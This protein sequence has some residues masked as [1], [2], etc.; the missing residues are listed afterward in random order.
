MIE[1]RND[2]T[3]ED[4]LEQ[5]T[6][7]KGERISSFPSS[8][9][10]VDIET[11][12]F[13]PSSDS[14][15]E[16]SA[17]KIQNDEIVNSF[18]SLVHIDFP[19]PSRIVKLTSITD[20]MLSTAPEID[21]VILEFTKFTG[22]SVVVG[23]NVSFDL[24][25][26]TEKLHDCY[27]RWF[28]NDYVDTL[29]IARAVLPDLTCHKL[30]ALCDFLGINQEQA[31][32]SLSDCTATWELF[33]ILK[34]IATGEIEAPREPVRVPKIDEGIQLSKEY[35]NGYF[36]KRLLSDGFDPADNNIYKISLLKKTDKKTQNSIEYGF[37]VFVFGVLALRSEYKGKWSKSFEITR[38]CQREIAS[39]AIPYGDGSV[40][41]VVLKCEEMANKLLDSIYSY[42]YNNPQKEF[43][44]CSR[45]AECSDALECVNPCKARSIVCGYRKKLEKGI[46]FYGKNRNV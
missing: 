12:G 36:T 11:T 23:H 32:R 28:Y 1:Y 31:H 39:D 29:Y 46:V 27:E 17:L 21:D 5:N 14:I 42:C 22:N 4:F 24:N 30:G 40:Y 37:S 44:C 43:D 41:H 15:I 38:F 25:F 16:I 33:G 45:F 26:I 10:V 35:I 13:N 9:V 6:R 34:S 19:L 18:S 8:Y 3:C 7:A 20:E 2:M